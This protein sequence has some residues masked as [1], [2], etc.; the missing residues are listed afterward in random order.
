LP[1]PI[2]TLKPR[3]QHTAAHRLEPSPTHSARRARD[4]ARRARE[5]PRRAEQCETGLC[6]TFV[7]PPTP[8]FDLTRNVPSSDEGNPM[9]SSRSSA[10]QRP[11]WPK[12]GPIAT[13]PSLA[14]GETRQS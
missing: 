1:S 2:K 5:K 8:P 11:T 4:K 7:R 13:G 9:S 10:G 3:V 12:L 6:S 14:R